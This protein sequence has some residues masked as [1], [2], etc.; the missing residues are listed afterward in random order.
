MFTP[1]KVFT[2]AKKNY[3]IGPFGQPFKRRRMFCQW[4]TLTQCW[5]FNWFESWNNSIQFKS[6]WLDFFFII[7]PRRTYVL[8]YNICQGNRV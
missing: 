1:K 4:R 6:R 2:K 8:L 3:T 5:R 7:F